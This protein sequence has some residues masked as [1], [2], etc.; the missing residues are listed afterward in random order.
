MRPMSI[1]SLFVLL[2]SSTTYLFSVPLVQ[3]YEANKPHA[4]TPKIDSPAK[5]EVPPP[6]TDLNLAAEPRL[7]LFRVVFEPYYRTSLSPVMLRP[8][9]N[10]NFRMGDRFQKDDI[11]IQLDPVQN[12]A[13]V[14]KA[15][16]ALVKAQ[17]EY[18]SRKELYRRDLSSLFEYKD[19]EAAL[20]LAK[21][22]LIVAQDNLHKTKIIAPYDGRVVDLY[23]EEGEYPKENTQVIEVIDDSIIRAKFLLPSR[24]LRY[25]S[26]GSPVEID[27]VEL[28]RKVQ[29][30][31]TRTGAVID[32]TSSTI[33]IE[34][35][36]KNP[37]RDLIPGMTGFV[38][39]KS[40]RGGNQ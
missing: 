21:A 31:V 30:I 11:L 36:I 28:G 37:R 18:D 3:T 16:A 29:G 24:Y 25:I 39:L 7:S 34:A 26:V 27:V 19:A 17:S 20:G 33:K 23:I 22:D 15:K 8:V 10:I 38:T 13:M 5:T 32:P 1:K 6:K 12:K 4:S 40:L 14:E 9:E 2:L 35:E